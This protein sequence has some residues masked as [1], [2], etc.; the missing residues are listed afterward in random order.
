[1]VHATVYILE[2]THV[3]DAELIAAL[4]AH[5]GNKFAMSTV[6]VRATGG[7]FG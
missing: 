1:M 6:L 7:L 5:K 4:F 3:P 2:T